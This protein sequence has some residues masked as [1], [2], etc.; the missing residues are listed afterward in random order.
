M[1]IQQIRH[2]LALLLLVTVPMAYAADPSSEQAQQEMALMA[3]QQQVLAAQ[4]QAIQTL[5]QHP[6]LAEVELWSAIKNGDQGVSAAQTTGAGKLINVVGNEGKIVRSEYMMPAAAFAVVGVFGLF[7]LFFL[8]NG[9]AKLAH[10]FSGKMVERWSQ[11][12]IWLH[13]FMAISCLTLMFTGLN[14]LLGR[15][16][17]QPILPASVWAALIYGS[18]TIHD[19]IS[20]VFIV[21]WVICILKWMPLQLFKM[22][23]LKW[24][25]SVGGYINFG[26]FK[27]KHPDSGFANAG[28][29]MWFW[30]LALFGLVVVVSGLL[31]LLPRLDLP[32]DVSVFALLAHDAAAVILIAFTI[33]HVWM[34]TVLSEGG[35]ESMVTGYC[36]ENWAIQHH[37]LWYDELKSDGRIKYK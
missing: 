3:Q 6:Q 30:T 15:F 22:Y 1:L 11:A 36:D 4:Q 31:L 28:E 34:A 26:P 35:L 18:K 7:L 5:Q 25:V 9:P 13:W 33:V 14:I 27:G 16:V 19:W 20:P 8:V 12:D 10:G 29:K 17:L 37:N 2:L 32:R 23:D 24:F 21:S